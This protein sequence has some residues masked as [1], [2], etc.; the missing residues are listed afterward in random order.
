MNAD[1]V[2]QHDV[3]LDDRLCSDAHVV[4]DL[5]EF[6]QHRKVT[7]REIGT[8][9]VS[10][11]DNRVGSELAF[12]S[13]HSRSIARRGAGDA[14]DRERI[15]DRSRAQ[16]DAREDL[17]QRAD[18]RCAHLLCH[19]NSIGAPL[20]AIDSDAASRMRVT[21]SPLSP[22]LTGALPWRMQSTK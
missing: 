12:W 17:R 13:D 19:L 1:A 20:R 10:R 5:V 9:P 3:M 18:G 11:I 7:S 6:T 21:R 16:R 8:D 14:D 22:S 2:A 4:S 15:H